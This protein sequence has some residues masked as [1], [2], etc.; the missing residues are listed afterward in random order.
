VP[1]EE[2]LRRRW[3]VLTRERLPARARAERWP[4]RLDHCFQRV[5][6]DQVCGG[7]W[8][9]HV[10]GRPAYRHLDGARL[11][12]AVALGERLERE[13]EPL[14]RRLDEDSLRWRGKAPKVP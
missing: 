10:S 1:D 8:Y 13:G 5:L 9:D 2:A 14:L 6:L 11:A 3:L 12:A 4:L 7:R